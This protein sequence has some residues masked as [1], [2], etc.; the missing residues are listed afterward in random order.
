MESWQKRSI[1]NLKYLLQKIQKFNLRISIFIKLANF[2][3][4][5]QNWLAQIWQ[6]IVKT[7]WKKQTFNY[8]FW[9]EC[10]PMFDSIHEC[11][12]GLSPLKS[13]QYSTTKHY[14]WACN[15]QYS[16]L[17]SRVCVQI[18]FLDTVQIR[19]HKISAD[20][21]LRMAKNLALMPDC[22]WYTQTRKRNISI[23]CND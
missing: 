20:F 21:G 18:E 1:L 8:W 23:I 22:V 14:F 16:Q 19:S 12:N 6:Q 5:N 11:L 13:I 10:I 7:F 15:S 17:Y 3:C 4:L 2:N 9:Y